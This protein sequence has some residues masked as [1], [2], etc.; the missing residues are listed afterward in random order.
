[1]LLPAPERSE[2]GAVVP[3]PPPPLEVTRRAVDA[4]NRHDLDDLRAVMADDVVEHV[5]PV[6]VHDG[7]R[8]VLAYYEE[9]FAAAPDFRID[10]TA[11]AVEGETVL[12]GWELTGTFT[13]A[14]FQGLEPTGGRIRL[15]GATVHIVREGRVASA[16]VMYDGASFARQVG[17]LPARGSAADRALVAAFNFRTRVRR[18][19]RRSPSRG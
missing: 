6:G 3:S 8:E 11:A 18:R 19:L 13:S 4:L 9:L 7:P 5:V 10:L 2:G 16:Q 17:L 12:V 15:E 14:R 1:M